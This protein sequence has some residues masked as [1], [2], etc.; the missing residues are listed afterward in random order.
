MVPVDAG[1]GLAR[2][3]EG[4]EEVKSLHAF[5]WLFYL[6]VI[7]ATVLTGGTLKGNYAAVGG[8]LL[9]A[10]AAIMLWAKYWLGP[11]YCRTPQEC[12]R[13]VTGG[14]YK[15]VRHPE[16]LGVIIAFLG[17]ALF[18]G[19]W[20]GLFA[21]GLGVIPVHAVLS[22]LEESVLESKFEKEYAE[23]RAAKG[24]FTPKIGGKGKPEKRE[25]LTG[26]RAKGKRRP[27]RG[28]RQPATS[29]THRP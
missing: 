20:E 22:Y 24:R 23:Y 9:V 27:P 18:E 13:L 16:Y 4:V 26:R 1:N 15:F 11:Q 17:F 29:R 8:V 19:S 2:L 12:E 5:I 7:A 10:G 25:R 3:V 14:P 6:A 21:W 28:R